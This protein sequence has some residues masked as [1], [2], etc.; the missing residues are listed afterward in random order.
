[1]AKQQ[2]RYSD[3]RKAEALAALAANAGDLSK[4][5]REMD[6]PRKTLSNWANGHCGQPP[7]TL[8]QEKKEDLAS[9]FDSFVSRSLG[10]TTDE[11]IRA[12]P[13]DKRMV[14][15]GIAV[16]KAALLRGHGQGD[17]TLLQ[18]LVYLPGKDNGNGQ[19]DQAAVG[20]RKVLEELG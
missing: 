13:L 9:L 14:A 11:E 6:V 10:V 20:T 12:T 4:T 19:T 18:V 1:M 16:D 17:K 7:A 3:E 8:S 5:A 15:V 2:Q